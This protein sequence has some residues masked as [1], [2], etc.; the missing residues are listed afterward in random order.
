MKAGIIG[1]FCGQAWKAQMRSYNEEV[2]RLG[3]LNSSSQL[4]YSA[5]CLDD[6]ETGIGLLLLQTLGGNSDEEC[7]VECPVS[8]HDGESTVEGLLYDDLKQHP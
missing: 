4:A 6:G 8:Q 2:I 5:G 3:Q 1:R 7:F